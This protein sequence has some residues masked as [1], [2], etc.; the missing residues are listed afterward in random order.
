MKKT[1][2]IILTILTAAQSASA[3][4]CSDAGFCSIGSFKHQQSDES[5]SRHKLGIQFSNGIGDESVYVFTPAIQYDLRLNNHWAIQAKL[6]AN[7][8]NGNLG[9]AFAPGD[10]ILTGSKTFPL[11]KKWKLIGTIGSKLPLS[12]SNLKSNGRS[13]PMQ[14]QSSLGT[15]DLIA[16]LSA[17]QQ[18]WSFSI[19]YQ[20]P[21]TGTN[22]NNFLHVY[23]NNSSEALK[24]PPGNDFNRKGDLLGKASYHFTKNKWTFIPGLL[25]IYH[26]GEDSYIDGNISNKPISLK[27]S[28]G[29]TLNGTLSVFYKANQKVSLGIVSGTPFVVRDIRPDGLTRKFVV[30]P[31]LTIN[32]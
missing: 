4:G 27:G 1:L 10:I 16:G 31:E 11:D 21:L 2:L 24:Y 32:F 20:Q 25:G 30:S 12:S 17:V 29:L 28:S 26:L 13:L 14:Y 8:A 19:A 5:S 23:F 3:Q 9:S 6:T 22:G 18:K 15:V 7:Y